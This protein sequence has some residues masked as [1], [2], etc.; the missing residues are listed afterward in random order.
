MVC[1]QDNNEVVLGPAEQPGGVPRMEPHVVHDVRVALLVDAEPPALRDIEEVN[2]LGGRARQGP[3]GAA[4]GAAVGLA[5]RDGKAPGRGGGAAGAQVPNPRRAVLGAGREAGAVALEEAQVLDGVG[6]PPERLHGTEARGVQDTNRVLRRR[7]S[8]GRP[9]TAAAQLEDVDVPTDLDLLLEQ[10][11]G[12]R[13]SFPPFGG[14]VPSAQMPLRLSSA[15]T[16]AI[17]HA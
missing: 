17:P 5:A 2:L 11:W 4:H 14:G 15:A 10:E 8:E 12:Q 3:V 6:V 1:V 7:S 16:A 13:H 9:V